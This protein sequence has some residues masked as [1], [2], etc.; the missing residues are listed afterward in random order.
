MIGKINISMIVAHGKNYELGLNNKLLWNIPEDLKK[1]KELTTG[2]HILMGRK[3]FESIG[4]PL[5]NRVS[6]VLTRSGFDTSKYGGGAITC[7]SFGLASEIAADNGDNEM[8]IIGGAQIYNTYIDKADTL[9]ISEVDYDG[10]AD[11]YLKPINYD[12][13]Q[14]IE[15]DEYAATETTPFWRFKKLIRL[16]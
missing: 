3:T 6:L 5:P 14:L 16:K 13:Y 11:A 1:F 8:F 4:R 10:P 2:H 9:Y 7:E 12:D 15:E